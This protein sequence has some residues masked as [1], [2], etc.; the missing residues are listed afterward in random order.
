MFGLETDLPVSFLALFRAVGLRLSTSI[1]HRAEMGAH[2]T[3]RALEQLLLLAGYIAIVTLFPQ[4][5]KVSGELIT[6]HLAVAE[7]SVPFSTWAS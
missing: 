3:S 1:Q 7:V 5:D 4:G 6:V 2:P